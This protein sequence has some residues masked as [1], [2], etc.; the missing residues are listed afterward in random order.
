M[1][2]L[3]DRRLK[4]A[5]AEAEA[6]GSGS[7]GYFVVIAM[8]LETDECS[9]LT[10]KHS[11]ALAVTV[12]PKYLQEPEVVPDVEAMHSL[13]AVVEAL[14]WIVAS[15][16]VVLAGVEVVV[17]KVV[18][19]GSDFAV[20]PKNLQVAGPMMVVTEPGQVLAAMGL[21]WPEVAPV[22]VVG[23]LGSKGAELGLEFLMEAMH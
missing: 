14:K 7:V 16:T 8:V 19:V 5:F 2:K 11:Q 1:G 23:L 20:E 10:R 6:E 13:V 21:K 15:L 4:S 22:V 3:F 12:V 17:P 9:P 18:E